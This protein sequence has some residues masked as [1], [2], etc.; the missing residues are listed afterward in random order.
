[1][2]FTGRQNGRLCFA[3]SR[4]EHEMLGWLF[5]HFPLQNPADRSLCRRNDPR[6]REAGAWLREALEEE[7]RS[8]AA[9]LRGRFTGPPAG[10]SPVRLQIKPDEAERLLQ[11]ANELRVGAWQRLGSPEN[12]DD[13]GGA[14]TPERLQWQAVMEIAGVVESVLLLGLRGC[15]D[16]PAG[17]PG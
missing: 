14:E 10:D 6:L 13:P 11:I 4:E 15:G 3:V 2:K 17:G 1:M 12:L 8:H 16:G 9:W 7:R 5:G